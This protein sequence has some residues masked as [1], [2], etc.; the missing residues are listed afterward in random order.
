MNCGYCFYR[1]E[2][3][4]RAISDRGMMSRETMRRIIE[5]V[6]ANKSCRVS[7]AFQGGEP[8]LMDI[9]FYKDFVSYVSSENIHNIPVSF[10]LQTNGTLLT[11]EWCDF[12]SEN[13]F[14]I[15]VSLDG[16]EAAHDLYRRDK[17]GRPTFQR[18][19]EGIRLLEKCLVDFNVL[20]V[21]TDSI[22]DQGRTIYRQLRNHGFRY[23]QFIPCLTCGG[24]G[25]SP[26]A[27]GRFLC[28]VFDAWFEDYT[29]G[30]YVSVRAFDNW[31]RAM[32]GIAPEVCSMNG[33][34]SVYGCIEA[35]GSVYPCDFY[36]VDT[37]CLGNIQSAS[38]QSMLQGKIAQDF[39]RRSLA[40]KSSECMNCAWHFLCKGGCR[41]NSINGRDIFCSA[42]QEFFPYVYERMRIAAAC[43]AASLIEEH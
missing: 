38:L 7:F 36:A 22:A 15:G 42:Y 33:R 27:Y 40:G 18:V 29:D 17:L 2:M 23:L 43:E 25:L 6:F 11:D 20:C 39:M 31:I 3:N 37:W 10:S 8:L 16:T 5:Q 34:C 21:I 19:M 35:D 41:R 30:S 12:F 32:I 1:E 24:I 13:R 14:L 9:G 4:S 28:D 26:S